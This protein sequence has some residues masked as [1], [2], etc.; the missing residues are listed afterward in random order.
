MRPG[1]Y[2]R[3]DR[4]T[5]DL[6]CGRSLRYRRRCPVQA[7]A[8]RST[9]REVNVTDVDTDRDAFEALLRR[10]GMS[11]TEA[12]KADL[13]V[14]YGHIVRMAARVRGDGQRPREAEPANMFKANG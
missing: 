4:A 8:D 6:G 13:F 11:I 7:R 10:S 12:Q 14:G 3:P 1:M 2:R 9:I 5:V